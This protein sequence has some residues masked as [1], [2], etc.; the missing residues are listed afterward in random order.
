MSTLNTAL[1]AP[2]AVTIRY[3][4]SY[5]F[6]SS[7]YPEYRQNYLDGL[8]DR[9][10]WLFTMSDSIYSYGNTWTTFGLN[11]TGNNNE[12]F[13]KVVKNR[14]NKKLWRPAVSTY[15]GY[16]YSQLN[17]SRWFPNAINPFCNA[18]FYLDYDYGNTVLLPTFKLVNTETGDTVTNVDY[19]TAK[20]TYNDWLVYAINITAYF[21]T[22]NEQGNRGPNN[23]AVYMPYAGEALGVTS[24]GGV[25]GREPFTGTWY[26][27]VN[28]TLFDTGSFY[29][30]DKNYNRINKGADMAIVPYDVDNL[31][32]EKVRDTDRYEYHY[33]GLTIEDAGHCVTALG[34]YWSKSRASATTAE[35]GIHCTDENIVGAKIDGNNKIIFS[36][37]DTDTYTGTQI[38]EQAE[39]DPDSNFNWGSGAEDYE[40]TTIP[41]IQENTNPDN[42]EETDSTDLNDLLYSS[43][44]TFN[45]AYSLTQFTADSIAQWL[46][47]GTPQLQ[48]SDLLAGLS[49]MGENPINAVVSLKM[50][51][52]NIPDVTGAYEYNTIYV[53]KNSTEIQARKIPKTTCIIDMGSMSY[54]VGDE[55]AFLNYEPYSSCHLYI[56]YCGIIQLS[57]T[58]LI[59]KNINVKLIV[60]F[61]TG[62][63][64]GVVLV[65]DIAYAYKD[66]VI[67][68]DIPI[69]GVNMSQYI[70]QLTSTLMQGAS[71]GEK[72]GGTV[73][74]AVAQ[75]NGIAGAGIGVG[76]G[77][78]A[79]AV[80]GIIA[81][82]KGFSISK[83]GASSPTC[84]LAEPQFCYLIIETPKQ[85]EWLNNYGH[86]RGYLSYRTGTIIS[87]T[88]T[89][90]S[91]FENVDCSGVS[92][93][94]ETE[95][96]EIKQLLETGVYL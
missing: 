13:K 43:A 23:F 76:L 27:G 36:N 6:N 40:G 4:L 8:I 48:W 1:Y 69:T 32:I 94:T 64:T 75:Q 86:T 18:S 31:F 11:N 5:P 79:V 46:W 85:I 37:P 19:N 70:T 87:L 29:T 17:G 41:E 22:Y 12:L 73:G 66:G 59:G 35:L 84:S 53:G 51:P 89:G 83:H 78:G 67:A 38:A 81:Q 60:D 50:F 65:N 16:G 28:N 80:G 57:P 39:L 56:P 30:I 47:N 21:G 96:N 9:S 49:L 20:E 25:I 88:G 72:L 33:L 3:T 93:A 95:K 2:N 52:F 58:E 62:A 63:C 90:F 42:A 71:V 74:N 54:D 10:I 82:T 24:S 34:H 77:V 92:G 55:L 61:I 44:G 26:N 91:I 14:L 68:V 15:G 7:S 45:T